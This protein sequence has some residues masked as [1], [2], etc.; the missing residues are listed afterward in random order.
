MPL[1]S[2]QMLTWK[3]CVTVVQ[4]VSITSTVIRLVH[5][6]HTRRMWWDD[7]ATFVPLLV[8]CLY[9]AF[10]WKGAQDQHLFLPAAQLYLLFYCAMVGSVV[11]VS[12]EQSLDEG[13]FRLSRVSLALSTARIFPAKHVCRR[14]A[15][16]ISGIFLFLYIGNVMIVIFQCW[17]ST[18]HNTGQIQLC[19]QK[20]TNIKVK[21]IARISLT[22]DALAEV[23]LV[24]APLVMLWRIRLPKGE[25]RLILSLFSSSILSFLGSVAF[26]VVW[27]L[28][29]RFGKQSIFVTKMT[30]QLQVA[31]SLLVCNLLVVTMLFYRIAQREALPDAPQ[32]APESRPRQATQANDGSPPDHSTSHVTPI[33][34]TSIYTSFTPYPSPLNSN[35]EHC[36]SDKES[37]RTDASDS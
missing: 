17:G 22:L 9:L 21:V 10:M 14:V 8:D 1:S 37:N 2:Q 15:L 13:N 35:P 16:W 30:A 36:G 18:V 19:A 25:R 31:V 20:S 27:V 33:T 32:P 4:A 11:L 6:W 7:W 26:F 34:F 23:I 12:T 29:R 28:A 24:V 5:R 3:V